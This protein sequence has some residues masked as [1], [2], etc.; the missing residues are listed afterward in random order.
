MKR[1]LEKMQDAISN[2]NVKIAY[3]RSVISGKI[4]S[5]S[6][7]GLEFET[8]NKIPCFK[9]MEMQIQIPK[10]DEVIDCKGT[11]VMSEQ[12]Q[13]KSKYNTAIYFDKLSLNV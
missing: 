11:V 12:L 9:R 5:I 6:K 13:E 10:I 7:K 1:N 4:N 2:K 3:G 8:D